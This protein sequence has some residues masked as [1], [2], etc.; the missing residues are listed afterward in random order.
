MTGSDIAVA[1]PGEAGPPPADGSDGGQADQHGDGAGRAGRL[2]SLLRRPALGALLGA[3]AV[4]VVFTITDSTPQHLWL[5]QTGFEAWAQQAAFFGIM[6]VPVGL[7]M[8]GGEFDLSTGGMT[9]FCAIIMALLVGNEHWNAW[10]AVAVTFAFGALIGAVNGLVVTRSGLPSFIV[11]LATYFVFRGLSVGGVL[12]VN[13][14]STNI[15]LTGTHHPGLKSAKDVFGG[16]FAHSTG[17]PAGYQTAILWFVGVTVAAVWLLGRTRFGNWVFAVGGD[18]DAARKVGVP[19]RRTK[20]LLFVG[21]SSA[22]ALVGVIS[23]L[24]SNTAVSEQGVGY[25][26]YYI[27]AAVVGGC[28]LTGGHGSAIGAALGACIIGMALQGVIYSGWDSSWDFTFLGA[29][30]FLAVAVN[31]LTHRRAMRARR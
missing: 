2:T 16:S 22:A 11:T 8:I 26:F 13:H 27:I 12:K 6:A 4:F 1:R 29:I 19:V 21:T 3:I 7:L 28:L 14:G 17:L 5:T 9:G 31:T 24:Q 18:A 20:V 10:A 25:E 23:F 30:L 15:G